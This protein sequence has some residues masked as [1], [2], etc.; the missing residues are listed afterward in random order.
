MILVWFGM[1][2]WDSNV[3]GALS[4]RVP[5]N[6]CMRE[7]ISWHWLLI[8]Q[9]QKYWGHLKLGLIVRYML[10]SC[11]DFCSFSCIPS[12]VCSR[13][14]LFNYTRIMTPHLL[15]TSLL[16]LPHLSAYVHLHLLTRLKV[17][18]STCII[19]QQSILTCNSCKA[20]F[21]WEYNRSS[22]SLQDTESLSLESKTLL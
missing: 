20:G 22:H 16:I 12:C 10:F 5:S 2:Q 19:R 1:C 15:E 11:I 8:Q 18:T 3:A 17:D 13:V 9:I 4:V 6:R 21:C 14:V 7:T